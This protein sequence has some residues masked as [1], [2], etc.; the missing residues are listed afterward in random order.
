MYGC[1]K[2]SNSPSYI[3]YCFNATFRETNSIMKDKKVFFELF[4]GLYIDRLI[5]RLY[6]PSGSTMSPIAIQRFQDYLLCPISG[7]A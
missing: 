6:Y 2:S 1:D 4:D 5:V 3:R 7:Q